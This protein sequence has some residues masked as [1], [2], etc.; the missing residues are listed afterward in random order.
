MHFLKKD[1][2]ALTFAKEKDLFY[3]YLLLQILLESNY[4]PNASRFTQ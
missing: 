4:Y 3:L 2:T 1:N